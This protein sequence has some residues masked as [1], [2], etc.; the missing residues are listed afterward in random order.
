MQLRQPDGGIGDVMEQ[1]GQYY[2]APAR[3]LHWT[4]ALLVFTML[5]VGLL[6]VQEGLERSL[7]DRLFIFHKNVGVIVGLL[8]ILRLAYRLLNPP[9]KLPRSLPRW[10]KRVSAWTHGILYGLIL[11]VPVSG[12]VRVRAGGFPIEML[13]S[14]GIGTFLPR[15]EALAATA[16]TIH[17]YGGLALIALIALHVGAALYHGL[18]K[19]DGVLH[20]M[21]PTRR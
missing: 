5:P 9:P 16:K 3:W 1:Q 21:W 4:V 8:V 7:Q 15:S 17:Y 14:M 2:K 12:Y 10:Q 13:D 11:M 6:M 20:R 18:I 19:R